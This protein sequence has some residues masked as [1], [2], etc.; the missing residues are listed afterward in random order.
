MTAASKPENWA[1]NPS[2]ATMVRM[3]NDPKVT[4]WNDDEETDS[5]SA[6]PRK[7]GRTLRDWLVIGA[8]GLLLFYV[9]LFIAASLM[10]VSP[11][12]EAGARE[13][14]SS[15]R[16]N[17]SFSWWGGSEIAIIPIQGEISSVSS[18][19]TTGYSDVVQALDDA[20]SDPAVRVIFLDIDSGGG[21]VVSS[22]QIVDKI[23]DVNKPIHAWIGD[24]GASGAYYIASSTDYVMADADS[25]TGSIGVISMQPNVEELLQKIGVKMNTVKTGELKDIG[26]PFSEM[27]VEEKAVLQTIVDEAFDAFKN[28]VQS[29]RGEKLNAEKFSQ[30]LDGRIL[31]GRQ[32]LEI[33]LVDE[34][35]SREKALQ[36][37]AES[38]GIT[39]KPVLRY[40]V[41]QTPSL[42]DVLFSAGTS[43][44]K[45]I[46]SGMSP[47]LESET[48]R[49][50]A[51]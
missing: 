49:I 36:R 50:Q 38:G 28:D 7:R 32:A 42:W 4:P 30:V 19:D 12:S 15:S 43:F 10:G 44:G 16:S 25:I 33:G 47:A 39:G 21:S 14:A 11:P 48:S 45:G 2:P 13:N 6:P 1:K 24:V 18:R 41:Q 35:L 8:A 29:F 46:S 17:A 9:V 51:T 26:S 34:T 27:S 37:A 40:Y 31:S 22:K 20:E 5:V 3:D 23:R